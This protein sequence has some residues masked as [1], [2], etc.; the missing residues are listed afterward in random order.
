MVL[1]STSLPSFSPLAI[2]LP[3]FKSGASM[4]LPVKGAVKVRSA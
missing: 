3:T 2:V 1:S 4:S